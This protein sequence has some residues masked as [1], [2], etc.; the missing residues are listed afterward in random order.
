ML[1]LK[2]ITAVCVSSLF[3][4]SVCAAE[5]IRFGGAC[6]PTSIVNCGEA[7]AISASGE[8]IAG[9]SYDG[10]KLFI[11]SAESGLVT[12][13]G[14]P[15]DSNA[16]AM[17]VTSS[18][19]IVGVSEF[20]SSTLISDKS[21]IWD[22]VIQSSTLSDG[23]I[24]ASGIS[25]D[26]T[27]VVGRDSF[28][29]TEALRW[30]VVEG[31]ETL[32]KLGSSGLFNYAV[33]ADVSGDGS[34]VVGESSTSEL[35]N[36]AIVWYEDGSYIGLGDLEGGGTTSRAF[37]VSKSGEFV[38]GSSSSGSI[39]TEAFFWSASDGMIG[40]GALEGGNNSNYALAVSDNQ[41]VIGMSEDAS[42]EV[43]F[44]WDSVTGMQSLQSVM[45]DAGV[46]LAGF[47]ME[48]VTDIS[49]DGTRI[50]GYGRTDGNPLEPFL[51]VLDP[52]SEPV[53]IPI[54]NIFAW[55]LLSTFVGLIRFK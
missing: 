15:N 51:V 4:Y 33:A 36:E 40:L 28:L 31:F 38:V 2:G 32:P 27:V 20:H 14:L 5:L 10:G 53:S 50:S 26:G 12:F 42:G 18:G 22:G 3:S 1:Y 25:E 48:R 52:P 41:R 6:T 30:S 54:P 35:F 16:E 45:E 39:V 21:F 44:V 8:Y 17:D 7:Y 34:V 9:K 24:Q 46:I 19:Q 55:L 47:T 23:Q 29:G 11:W 37:G 49:S 13:E 43:P